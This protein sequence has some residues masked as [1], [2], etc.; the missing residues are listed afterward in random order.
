MKNRIASFTFA[1]IAA[2]ALTFPSC[3]SDEELNE[4]VPAVTYSNDTLQATF[5]QAGNSVEPNINWNGNTGTL[6]L[7]PQIS[8]LSINATTGAIEWT[9][10]LPIGT[11]PFSVLATNSAGTS[12]IDL[13][14]NNPF[15]GVFTGTYDDVSFYELEFFKDGSIH[16][17][18]DDPINPNTA[19]GTWTKVGD[20]IRS[21]YTYTLGGE[22]SL[23]GN[24]T[25]SDSAVYSGNWFNGHGTINGNEGGVFEV[26][27]H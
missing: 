26:V 21:D 11:H 13:V 27:M 23:L 24:L 16:I 1:G 25:L 15:Q 2:V 5:F 8:G 20:S 19:N 12:S 7:S 22:F 18:A 6:S 9:K 3:S 14:I 10:Q 17:R 4:L